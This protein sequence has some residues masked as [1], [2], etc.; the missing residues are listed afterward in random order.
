MK[1]LSILFVAFLL[2]VSMTAQESGSANINVFGGYSFDDSVSMELGTAK[3]SGG[4]QWGIGVEYFASKNNSVELKYL[5]SFTTMSFDPIVGASGE[6]DGVMD[7]YLLGGNHY[8]E[9]SNAKLLPYIGGSIGFGVINPDN[10]GSD[11][12]FAWGLAAGLKIKTFSAISVNLQGYL[13]SMTAAA[14]QDV[15]YTWYGL[16]L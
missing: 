5:R 16:L 3:F 8:F 9:T 12:N 7:Y 10:R 11:T 6:S 13:Q 1:N 4:V 14:G 15:Y 2:T